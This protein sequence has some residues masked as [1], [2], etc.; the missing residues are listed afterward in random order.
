MK[1]ARLRPSCLVPRTRDEAKLDK[2]GESTGDTPSTRRESTECS[3]ATSTID[4]TEGAFSH[5]L[6]TRPKL[7][8]DFAHT[9]T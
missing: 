7:D 6:S 3:R 9:Q 5:S 4:G 8:Y 2:L 1:A